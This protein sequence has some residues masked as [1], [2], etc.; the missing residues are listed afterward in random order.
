MKRSL[1]LIVVLL[2]VIALLIMNISVIHSSFNHKVNNSKE[3]N[4]RTIT[5]SDHIVLKDS[6]REK[7]DSTYSK[8]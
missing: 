4:E 1:I 5:N 2:F 6:L 3:P 7:S 8:N